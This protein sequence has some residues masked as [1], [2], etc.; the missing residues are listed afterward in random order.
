MKSMIREIN[1]AINR[2]QLYSFKFR[3][4]ADLIKRQMLG[5]GS[6]IFSRNKYILF[7][8]LS[9]ITSET[10]CLQ[11][12]L[13]YTVVSLK[14]TRIALTSQS[15]MA[16]TIDISILVYVHLFHICRKA[17]HLHDNLLILHEA[18]KITPTVYNSV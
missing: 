8:V 5:Q 4:L 3:G 10:Q 2:T 17:E 18:H 7:R 9:L 1:T 6:C 13:K 11:I 14:N 12:S 15:L 16:C